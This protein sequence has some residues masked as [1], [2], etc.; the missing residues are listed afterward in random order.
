MFAVFSTTMHM[1][2]QNKL[3]QIH[4]EIQEQSTASA[5]AMNDALNQNMLE[6]HSG[7]PFSSPNTAIQYITDK[8]TL[9]QLFNTNPIEFC[10]A[11][12]TINSTNQVMQSIKLKKLLT[13]LLSHNVT[14]TYQILQRSVQ[15]IRITNRLMDSL[16]KIM[17][18]INRRS[19]TPELII[20]KLEIWYGSNE[21]VLVKLK[22][23]DFEKLKYSVMLEKLVEIICIPR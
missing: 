10:Y 7:A 11:V 5:P 16:R 2:I 17:S 9:M 13:F 20:S 8:H 4:Y 19:I 1:R 14:S 22:S 21:A 18:K 6:L 3:T 12:H 23:D 15:N